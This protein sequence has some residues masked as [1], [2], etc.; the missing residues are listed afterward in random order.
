MVVQSAQQVAASFPT[1]PVRD[2]YIAAASTLRIPYWD[3]AVDTN[4]GD[5]L[6]D[7]VSNATIS[8]LGPNG[9][10]NIANPLYSY[11]FQTAAGKAGLTWYP[12]SSFSPTKKNP[13]G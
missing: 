13:N 11:K 1:G 12:V 6:P 4:G 3:W 9:T 7:F 5:S 2:N 8:V 10:E